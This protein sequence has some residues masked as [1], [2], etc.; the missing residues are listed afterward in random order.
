MGNIKY[1]LVED[2]TS[3]VL[4]PTVLAYQAGCSILFYSLSSVHL[5]LLL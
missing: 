1:G 3:D 2:I 4:F 5:L